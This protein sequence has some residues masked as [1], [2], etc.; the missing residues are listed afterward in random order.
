MINAES[1]PGTYELSDL[2]LQLGYQHLPGREELAQLTDR[3][4]LRDSSCVELVSIVAVM[5]P[6]PSQ[7]GNSIRHTNPVKSPSPRSEPC[8]PRP[9][10]S[11]PGSPAAPCQASSS[12][13]LILR[14]A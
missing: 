4:L 1:F 10:F 7:L 8:C 11:A 12:A 9:P 5:T 6:F 13:K 3:A 2:R 14:W